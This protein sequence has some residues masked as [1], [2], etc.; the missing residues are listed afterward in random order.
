MSRFLSPAR[1][2]KGGHRKGPRD[3]AQ[4]RPLLRRHHR[5]H[6]SG[7][8]FPRAAKADR[9]AGHWAT[10]GAHLLAVLEVTG[11]H[12]REPLR[13]GGV[14]PNEY[15]WRF[16]GWTVL[17]VTGFSLAHSPRGD[18]YHVLQGWTQVSYFSFCWCV[19]LCVF[20]L[21]L[22]I[23]VLCKVVYQTHRNVSILFLIV[24]YDCKY[25]LDKRIK[26]FIVTFCVC[27]GTLN[28]ESVNVTI[29]KWLSDKSSK[30]KAV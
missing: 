21:C 6:G 30:P 18:L 23:S 26:Y 5:E 2:A 29:I 22:L 25:F 10:V 20:F 14:K 16:E 28:W 12:R 8:G 17:I 15:S 9:Q 11:C 27:D 3:G 4:L 19:S 24:I 1:R 13:V 7:P